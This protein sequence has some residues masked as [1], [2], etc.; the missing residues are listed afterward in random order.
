MQPRKWYDTCN[1]HLCRASKHLHNVRT[2]QFSRWKQPSATNCVSASERP[3]RGS[4]PARKWTAR[5]VVVQC[6][7]HP[8][9][10]GTSGC[11]SLYELEGNYGDQNARHRWMWSKRFAMRRNY[12]S[13]RKRPQMYP[14][15]HLSHRDLW[16]GLKEPLRCP[17]CHR[18]D[19]GRSCIETSSQERPHL[20]GRVHKNTKH[21]LHYLLVLRQNHS[22]PR[23]AQQLTRHQ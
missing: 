20:E 17:I 2:R 12:G 6:T 9:H 14:G 5:H 11:F 4:A 19:C 13:L 8:D 23:Q 16:L 21:L 10:L 7:A 1:T 18:V 3:L 15:L 22:Y